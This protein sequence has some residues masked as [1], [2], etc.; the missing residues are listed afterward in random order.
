[1]AGAILLAEN[2]GVSLNSLD[3]DHIIEKIR[4]NFRDSEDLVRDEIYSPVDDGGMSFIS[5][6]EQ[7]PD[8]FNAFFRAALIAYESETGEQPLSSY[9]S[10]W[11]ELMTALRS[12]P[13]TEKTR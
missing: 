8:G 5:L 4:P 3:F 2:N 11:D 13:R 9:R 1:M 12:D 7:S 10:S 6:K